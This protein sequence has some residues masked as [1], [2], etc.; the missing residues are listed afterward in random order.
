MLR[1]RM[2]PV[3][4][5]LL[6]ALSITGCASMNGGG[7]SFARSDSEAVSKSDLSFGRLLEK[8]GQNGKARQVYTQLA[9]SKATA[10]DANHRLAVLSARTGNADEARKHFDLCL[11]ANPHHAEAL[12]DYGYFLFQQGE[13]ERAEQ[14]TRS[15]LKEAPENKRGTT[16]LALIVGALGRYDESFAIFQRSVGEAKAH[17]NIAFMHTQAGDLDQAQKHYSRALTVDPSMRSASEALIQ[18]TELKKRVDYTVAQREGRPLP[19]AT[20]EATILQAK[21]EAPKKTAKS[22]IRPIDEADD[23]VSVVETPAKRI[24]DDN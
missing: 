4:T 15:A 11:K 1:N 13:L 18:V 3:G 9:K 22:N 21:A 19:G 14:L 20:D 24:G 12:C 7:L 6:M 23:I 8:K 5:L 17:A 2:L 10:A 16:N